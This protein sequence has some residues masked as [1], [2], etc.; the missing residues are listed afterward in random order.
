MDETNY[1]EKRKYVRV[2]SVLK[3]R[4][5]FIDEQVCE[6]LKSH[7]TAAL[8][9]QAFPDRQLETTGEDIPL[10]QMVH[11]AIDMLI[12]MNSKIDRL[13]DLLEGGRGEQIKAEVVESVDI[14]GSGMSFMLSSPVKIGQLLQISLQVADI[15]LGTFDVYGKVIWVTPV[16]NSDPEL[17]KVGI[18]FVEISEEVRDRLIEYSFVRQ[19]KMIRDKKREK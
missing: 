12:R 18:E 7:E 13:L 16:E 4:V 9:S 6:A 17:F 2:G 10:S 19:R 14:S 15:P 11:Y 1:D 5:N 3:A 8:S